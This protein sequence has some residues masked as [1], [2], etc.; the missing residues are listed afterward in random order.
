MCILNGMMFEH[1]QKNLRKVHI[2]IV[3][4]NIEKMASSK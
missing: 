2:H 3:D 4:E 1:R